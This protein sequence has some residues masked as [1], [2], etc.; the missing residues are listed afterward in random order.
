MVGV[1]ASR[2]FFPYAPGVPANT[3]LVLRLTGDVAEVEGSGV[4]DQFLPGQP[5]VRSL[6]DML[7][8]AKTDT[9]IQALLVI[10]MAGT[11]YWGK[12]QEIRDAILDFR[13][14][15]KKT[16]AFLEFAGEQEYYIA[17]A[18]E[19]I[20][21]LPSSNLSVKGLATYEVFLRGTLDK[22]GAVPDLMHIGDFKTA[23]NTFTEKTFTP[24]HREMAESLNHDAFEQLVQGIAEGR[25][26]SV[27][28][29]RA[30]ID[31]GPFLP[32]DA[33]RTGLVD[34]LAYRDQLADKAKLSLDRETEGEVYA[35]GTARGGFRLPSGQRIALIY[36]VGTI[37]SG[38]SGSGANG[39]EFTGSDTLAKYIREARQDSTIKAVVLRIDSPGGSSVASDV[40]WRELMLTRDKKPLIVSMS[41]FAASG[42]YYIA[43]PAHAIVAQPGTLTGSIGIFQGK[44]VTGGVLKKLGANIEGVSEGK[45]ADI[46]SP[47]RP[48]SPEERAKLEEQMQA[49]YDQF[50]EKVAQARKST[51]EKIDAIAQGRVWTGRQAREI[52]LVDELGGLTKAIAVARERAKIPAGEDLQIVVYPPRKSFYEALSEPFGQAE[53]SM[54]A[55][56]MGHLFSPRERRVIADLSAPVRLLQRREPLAL[57]PFVFLR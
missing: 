57:M 41:D 29:V 23:V 33:L 19:R 2:V 25:K 30:L 18:C 7:Q 53:Q 32:E 24:A 26:K 5:T 8:R 55:H 52:G 37:A 15:G 31:Q 45:F 20:F 43:M 10:P 49:F 54:Q 44:F 21:L 50:V 12:S 28:D 4:L 51:P 46:D 36:A 16:V 17:T 47:V 42:G 1:L 13:K 35:R 27:A 48:Y 39:G 3:T 22:I 34:D 6:V 14:S 9:R 40:I 38:E 11:P 56:A